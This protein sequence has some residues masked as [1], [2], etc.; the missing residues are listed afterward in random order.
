MSFWELGKNSKY[1]ILKKGWFSGFFPLELFDAMKRQQIIS[2]G[3]LIFLVVLVSPIIIWLSYNPTS[4]KNP[5]IALA[6]FN[7]FMALSTLSI[8]FFLSTRL[9]FF[10][11]LF[12]GLD[13]MY[14]VHKIIG[15]TS[16]IFII[17]HPLFLILSQYKNFNVV[18]TYILPIGYFEVAAGVIAVYLFL[19]LL[20]LTVAVKLP[21]HWWHNS[22]KILGI[23]LL[24][25]GFHAVFAGSDISMYPVLRFWVIFLCCLGVISWLYMLIFYK[26]I[27]PK[28]KVVID[29]VDQLKDVTEV[30]FKKPKGFTY[31]PG[32]FLFI[33]F[34]RFEGY[35]ELF[36]F[37]ISSDP[38]QKIIRISVKRSGD[39]TSKKIPM[40]KKGDKAIIM[41]PYGT[42]GESYLLHDKDMVWI[43]GGIGITPFLSLAKHE[44]NFPSGRKIVLYWATKNK[45]EAFHDKELKSETKRN[46]NFKYIP[47]FSNKKGLLH[48]NDIVIGLE[49]K[50]KLDNIKILMCGPPPMMYSLSRGF[51]KLGVNYDNII[52]EDFNMLD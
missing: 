11:T 49:E 1:R 14:R 45:E 12:N 33:R 4:I 48:V 6:K 17:L 21:Y 41:G 16:L 42:F 5:I 47:W 18:I 30:M 37:S 24:L 27:G 20:A 7:A 26:V 19:M 35:K 32:Q 36:P 22:H 23:V 46:N 40:L 52:F 3:T 2:Y 29:K 28:F 34:P 8:N 44:S 43:A 51:N 50:L 9:K 38:S 13:R 31:Q 25:V 39:F 15:R 10:E